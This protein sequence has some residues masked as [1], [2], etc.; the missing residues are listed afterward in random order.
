MM[1]DFEIIKELQE[2]LQGSDPFKT[3]ILLIWL[4]NLIVGG[5]DTHNFIAFRNGVAHSAE[6]LHPEVFGSFNAR[7]REEFKPEALKDFFSGFSKKFKKKLAEA[8]A[9]KAVVSENIRRLYKLSQSGESLYEFLYRVVVYYEITGDKSLQKFRNQIVH[10]DGENIEKVLESLLEG[11]KALKFDWKA[12]LSS[13]LDDERDEI[14][15]S[16]EA[17][18]R[19]ISEASEQI[20]AYKK[21]YPKYTEGMRGVSK[22]KAWAEL[23]PE[24]KLE[25]SEEKIKK[26]SKK[27]GV[28]ITLN[29]NI[30]KKNIV[31]FLEG[32][33]KDL[34][35]EEV[36]LLSRWVVWTDLLHKNVN[37]ANVIKFIPFNRK[38]LKEDD[39]RRLLLK[40][41]KLSK[42]VIDQHESIISSYFK[43]GDERTM[44][45][46]LLCKN[47]YKQ[48]DEDF[49]GPVLGEIGGA[50]LVLA[51]IAKWELDGKTRD[52][53]YSVIE[54]AAYI[55]LSVG[56]MDL[57]AKL[58][59]IMSIS[60]ETALDRL[61]A[62]ALGQK[63]TMTEGRMRFTSLE[64]A[65]HYLS[66]NPRFWTMGEDDNHLARPA[67]RFMEVYG[68]YPDSG[69]NQKRVVAAFGYIS[70]FKIP[71]RVDS[72]EAVCV[73]ESGLRVEAKGRKNYM[74]LPTHLLWV[75][76]DGDSRPNWLKATHVCHVSA[77]ATYVSNPELYIPY[78][79]GTKRTRYEQGYDDSQ[80]DKKFIGCYDMFFVDSMWHRYLKE[81]YPDYLDRTDF[82]H[83]P[84]LTIN[85]LPE[86]FRGRHGVMS[87]PKVNTDLTCLFEDLLKDPRKV[88]LSLRCVCRYMQSLQLVRLHCAEMDALFKI[89]TKRPFEELKEC[90]RWACLM[91]SCERDR[92]FCIP[93]T[94]KSAFDAYKILFARMLKKYKPDM[95]IDDL[96]PGDG[97]ERELVIKGD[98]WL[99]RGD[100]VK[101]FVLSKW[102][103]VSASPLVEG[104]PVFLARI[105]R[106]FVNL[107]RLS[108]GNALV[109]DPR[110]LA[111]HHCELLGV[112]PL[113]P[114]CVVS[115]EKGKAVE[116]MLKL[117]GKK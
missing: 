109:K 57:A 64:V 16:Y 34:S 85:Q 101:D 78:V 46:D 89:F 110:A 15:Q 65:G 36:K 50:W 113:P 45:N 59:S 27:V 22:I 88:T 17:L 98:S 8:K 7:V 35:K 112:K 68:Y 86:I 61:F 72:V 73:S 76:I 58:A 111:V 54:Y 26:E 71:E 103:A 105:G 42:E 48:A 70:E 13:Q 51:I 74:F 91:F 47:K 2:S 4:R 66:H 6:L 32:Y 30:I 29:Q 40:A 80:G 44:V 102:R 94:A 1:T 107:T 84:W 60:K 108:G 25:L 69:R 11:I 81:E 9:P 5:K 77:M 38:D 116:K 117:S 100:G 56:P 21:E 24:E 92:V 93:E 10:P 31:T 18:L 104:N 14:R 28:T 99:L 49:L 90:V 79:C 87:L 83:I 3:A 12:L 75:C 41:S 33:E 20:E 97:N 96:S 53:A 67:G 95:S 62:G 114:I 63:Q 39:L 82:Y 43:K 19:E 55:N 115:A 23:S 37:I 52:I 106:A